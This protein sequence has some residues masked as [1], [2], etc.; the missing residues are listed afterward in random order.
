M[1]KTR[2][3]SN[4][5]FSGTQKGLTTVGSHCYA[6]SGKVTVGDT[7]TDLLDFHSGKGYIVAKVQM[8]YGQ[9][10][11]PDDYEY[12]ITFNGIEVFAY[13]VAHS[14]QQTEPDT[15]MNL[16]IPPL[17]QVTIRARNRTDDTTNPQYAMLVGRQYDA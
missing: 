14:L 16:L 8:G 17:T 4:A 7:V 6:F 2:I 15:V 10:D 5:T 12:E 13:V 1:A 11:N 9:I 3:G